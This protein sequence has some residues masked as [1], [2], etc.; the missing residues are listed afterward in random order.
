MVSVTVVIIRE[1][2]R[3]VRD[4]LPG[5]REATLDLRMLYRTHAGRGCRPQM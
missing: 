4:S 1:I 5:L 3:N 2:I